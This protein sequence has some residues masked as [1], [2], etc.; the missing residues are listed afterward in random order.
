[1]TTL[2]FRRYLGP[3]IAEVIEPFARLRIA[4]FRDWPYL[5]DGDLDYE[6]RYL[7]DY[8]QGGAILV[9]AYAGE[10][11]VGASTGMPLSDHADEFAEALTSF[12][13]DI[14]TIFYCAE[15]VLLP[16]HRGQGAYRRFFTEREAYARARGFTHATF[17]GVLRPD[18]HPLRPAGHEP[19][20][21]VWRRYG[22]AP[23]PGAIARFKWR[24]I[25]QTAETAKPLQFWIKPLP[26]PGNA[27][28]P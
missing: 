18:D 16:D 8:A 12:S 19:L 24:D 5:Y 3:E 7:A 14:K 20:D 23:V 10:R 21:P 26:Q 22:Y 25:G 27:D 1:M 17:C 9:A 15:S 2:S 4:V 6:R 13:Q 28:S 11:L